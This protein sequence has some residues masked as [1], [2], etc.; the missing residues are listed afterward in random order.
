MAIIPNDKRGMDFGSAFAI[1]DPDTTKILREPFD[2]QCINSNTIIDEY[3]HDYDL[4]IKS[5]ISNTFTGL[6]DFKYRCYSNGTTE[7]FDK[8][9]MKNAKRRFRC[10]KGEYM[11]HKLAWR[12]KFDWQWIEDA[13]IHKNDAVIISLPFADTGNVHTHYYDLM[14]KCSELGVPVLVDCAYFGACRS[15]QFDVAYPC[16]TDV[17]FSL[18]KSFPV[19]YARIGIRYTRVDDDDTLFVYHKINYNNKIGAALG[20]KYFQKFTP[21]YITQKYLDKQ[22]DFCNTVDV[23]PSKTVLFGI[24][25]LGRYKE[26]N[27]GGPSNRL[28]FHK[29]YIKGLDYART[30]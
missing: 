28:S 8:F 21:D 24:D 19:A 29:Q 15:I 9:Y 25:H 10:Y 22:L 18:S 12:D 2:L 23:E 11:Y 26:Y 5:S 4:W 7:A 20:L 6:E 17:V 1:Q 3:L 13:P 27:R 16:I 30:E 14:R